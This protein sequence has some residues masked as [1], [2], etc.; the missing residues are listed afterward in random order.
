MDTLHLQPG[1]DPPAT[2]WQQRALNAEAKLWA[3]ER[4]L[5]PAPE[6]VV[7]TIDEDGIVSPQGFG[8]GPI[9]EG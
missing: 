4:L 8:L 5:H 6:E 7:I 3:I 1:G 2:N 9:R